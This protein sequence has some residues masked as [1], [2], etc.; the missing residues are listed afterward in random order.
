VLVD[1]LRVLRFDELGS[2]HSPFEIWILR[3]M[4]KFELDIFRNIVYNNNI[5][6]L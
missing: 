6:K 5:S 4:L 2:S 1:V 3:Q